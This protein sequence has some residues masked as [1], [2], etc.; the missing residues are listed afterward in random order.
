MRRRRHRPEQ[1]LHLAVARFL[2]VALP[3]D[4]FWWHTPNGGKRGIVEAK[5]FK[6]MGVKAGV[7]DI[8]VLYA[9]TLHGIELKAP[10]GRVSVSQKDAAYK[11]FRAGCTTHDCRSVESVE[12]A[13]R[14][15]GVPLRARS[16]GIAIIPE[17][18]AA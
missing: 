10:K 3:E 9:G 17:E 5:L 14:L 7:P 8:F 15:A 6:L 2:S 12:T 4:A 16:M 13:L 11:L 18:K 1:T